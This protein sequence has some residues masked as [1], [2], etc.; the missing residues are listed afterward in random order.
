MNKSGGWWWWLV[1]QFIKAHSV[2][3]EKQKFYKGE[4]NQEGDVRSE[5]ST[6][7]PKS[8][9]RFSNQEAKCEK[10][11]KNDKKT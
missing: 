9:I 4:E 6:D 3:V 7:P 10:H 11:K 8:G 1:A 2:H 5:R